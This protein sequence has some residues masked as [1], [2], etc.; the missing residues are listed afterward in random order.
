MQCCADPNGTACAR[1]EAPNSEVQPQ[2]PTS[3]M[4]SHC[5]QMCVLAFANA[6]G[7]KG[8]ARRFGE[9]TSGTPFCFEPHPIVIQVAVKKSRKLWK[10][11]GAQGSVHV[12]LYPCW[13]LAISGCT[14]AANA[15]QSKHKSG[16][17][18]G[19][20]W[21]TPRGQAGGSKYK[22]DLNQGAKR[23]CFNPSP[24]LAPPR[25]C[26]THLYLV[27]QLVRKG[28]TL[29]SFWAHLRILIPPHNS[30]PCWV[31]SSKMPQCSASFG[32]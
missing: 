18:G 24:G 4:P 6:L 21:S 30:Y 5:L 9:T 27:V 29:R 31:F 28:N 12:Q 11:H 22:T 23:I 1:Y 25:L 17:V 13:E 20:T 16:W 26:Y 14:A 2:T 10:M 15:A 7:K 19:P 32:A 8:E 3:H